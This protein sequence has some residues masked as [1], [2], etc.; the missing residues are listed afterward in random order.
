MRPAAVR[1]VLVLAVSGLGLA[2]GEAG[3]QTSS[4]VYDLNCAICHQKGGAGAPGAFPRLAGRAGALAAL[5]S[6]RRLLIS[7]VLF[8]MSGALEAGGQTI[9][10]LMPPLAQ[11]ND[12]QVA[13]A[14]NYI[15]SLEGRKPRAFT[16]GEVAAVRSQGR[17]TP[18]QVNAMARDD[19][20]AKVAP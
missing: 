8:G 11:L 1:A 6:G 14:L 15:A 20:P 18:A 16:A 7:T 10:G 19:A 2:G 12:A 4:P 17:L 9:H 5:P 3:A 13:E